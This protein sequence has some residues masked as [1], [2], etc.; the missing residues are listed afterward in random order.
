MP[1]RGLAQ[2]RR[3]VSRTAPPPTDLPRPQAPHG[4]PLGGRASLREHERRSENEFF[5]DGITEDVIAHLARIRMLRVIS[6]SSVMA[7]RRREKTLREIG[8]ELGVGVLVDGSV[9][10]SGNRVRIVAQLV[11]PLTDAPLWAETYDR[12]LDDIFAIQT[13]VALHI[14]A[15]LSAELSLEEKAR[16][17]RRPTR[18]LEAYELY[19]QGRHHFVKFTDEGVLRSLALFE[20]AVARDP[21]SRRVRAMAHAHPLLCSEGV[22]GV[23][24]AEAF[25]AQKAVE[26]APRDDDG[27][28]AAHGHRSAPFHARFRLRRG[29]RGGIPARVT[30]F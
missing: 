20:A 12:E 16:I 22:R 23:R 5:A 8:A 21:A 4:L 3:A 10:R 27:L 1:R 18:D 25:G 14:A 26:A 7:F 9:R 30:L 15:A 19:L 13:D 17:A 2:G 6:R 24:P 28:A 29:R 11:D